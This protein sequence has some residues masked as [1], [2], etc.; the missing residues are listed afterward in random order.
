MTR[1][2]TTVNEIAQRIEHGHD[3]QAW[4]DNQKAVEVMRGTGGTFQGAEILCAGVVRVYVN[5]KRR[6]VE[7]YRG[8]SH[9]SR[10]T[11][12]DRLHELIK[13]GLNS[14]Y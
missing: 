2:S 14:S 7:G 5:T 6:R 11:N 4:L 12:T 1:L 13:T 3:L 9:Y 10:V 8:H